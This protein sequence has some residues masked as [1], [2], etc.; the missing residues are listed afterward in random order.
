M[1]GTT[2][3]QQFSI[4][5][6]SPIARSYRRYLAKAA[7]VLFAVIIISALGLLN[8][9]FKV[10]MVLPPEATTIASG[11]FKLLGFFGSLIIGP[12]IYATATRLVAQLQAAPY[13]A[14]PC[15]RPLPRSEKFCARL[16]SPTCS[17]SSSPSSDSSCV[18]FRQSGFW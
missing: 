7:L 18:S 9:S 3:R 5:D 12:V 16:S 8:G 1:S 2:S 13:A 14:L 4:S 6:R 10:F 15:A 11:I 17:S